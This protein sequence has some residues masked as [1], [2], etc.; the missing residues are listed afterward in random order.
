MN[1]KQS[2][3]TTSTAKIEYIN[4]FIY[5]NV[6]KT[7]INKKNIIKIIYLKFQ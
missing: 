7:Y 3:V 6:T 5:P 4:M 2:I 1:K